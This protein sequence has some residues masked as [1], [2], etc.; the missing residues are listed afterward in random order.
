MTGSHTYTAA[1]SYH[2]NITVMD[3]GGMSTTIT[4]TATVA[5]YEPLTEVALTPPHGSGTP[6]IN[7]FLGPNAGLSSPTDPIFYDGSFYVPNLAGNTVSQVPFNQPSNVMTPV[8]TSA[9]LDTPDGLAF[10]KLGDLFIANFHANFLTEVTAQ[11]TIVPQFAPIKNANAPVYDPNNGELYVCDKYDNL[12]D[13]VNPTTGQVTTYVGTGFGLSNPI[14]LAIDQAGDLYVLS[15]NNN[16]IY[17]VTPG[18]N[19]ATALPTP[20]GNLLD[21]PTSMVMG[22]DGNLYVYNSGNS[23]VIEVAL[24]SGKQSTYAPLNGSVAGTYAGLVFGPDGY[25]YVAN[26][27]NNTMSQLAPASLVEG[28]GINKQTV[29]HFTDGNTSDTPSDYSATVNLGDGQTVTLNSSGGVTG[30]AGA[31]LQIVNDP[32]GGFDVQLTYPSPEFL[33]NA[34]NSVQVSANDA[35]TLGP[36]TANFSVLDAPLEGSSAATASGAANVLNSSVLSNATF[37][38]ANPGDHQSDFTAVI[39]WGGNSLP[40]NGQ[41]VYQGT[42]AGISTYTVTGSHTYTAAGSYPIS[43]TV[44]DAGGKTATI[45]GTAKVAAATASYKLVFTTQP[46]SSKAGASIS[47]VVQVSIEDSHNHV[48][49]S[50]TSKV[51]VAIGANPGNGTLGGTLTVAAINGVATFRNLWINKSGTGYT[52]GAADGSLSGGATTSRSFSVTP[53]AASKLVFTTQPSNTAVGVAISP[54]VQVSVEDAYGNVVTS[55]TSTVT[56]ALGANP[57]RGKL[58][59]GLTAAVVRGLATFRNLSISKLG[60]GYTLTAKDGALGKAASRAFNITPRSTMHDMASPVPGLVN[61]A[62]LSSLMESSGEGIK[63][64]HRVGLVDSSD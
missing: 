36:L 32:A 31:G 60:T 40:S 10:D 54:A 56:V 18:G 3:A 7:Q 14:D 37:T 30:P 52:L 47:P 2:I 59:G 11:G 51:T 64:R 63:R 38:D 5:A 57:G 13:E 16:T 62:A 28:Q 12:I 35:A 45:M 25:L 58:S 55:N 8:G 17:E 39:N 41:V 6:T 29:L 22:P 43:I 4:G 48:V 23:A 34:T 61:D 15:Q 26:D 27:A 9:Q 50:N 1:E 20:N 21:S 33:S 42:S 46:S 53:A 49:T 44:T 19:N 24:P